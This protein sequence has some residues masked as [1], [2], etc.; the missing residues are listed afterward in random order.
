M[1]PAT[2][3]LTEVPTNTCLLYLRELPCFLEGVV[4]AGNRGTCSVPSEA[5]A[6]PPLWVGGEVRLLPVSMAAGQF[7]QAPGPE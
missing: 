7:S 1:E 5:E 2:G 6:G 3:R 4:G